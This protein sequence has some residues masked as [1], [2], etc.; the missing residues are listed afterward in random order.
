M[1]D[2]LNPRVDRV[3]VEYPF[4]RYRLWTSCYRYKLDFVEAVEILQV[5]F[6]EWVRRDTVVSGRRD[7]LVRMGE[8]LDPLCRDDELDRNE[9]SNC[10]SSRTAYSGLDILFLFSG[11]RELVVCLPQEAQFEGEDGRRTLGELARA[12]LDVHRDCFGGRMVKFSMIYRDWEE[13]YIELHLG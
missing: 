5:D 1:A 7:V 9:I 6:K 13:K 2:M 4:A 10:T 11:L 12:F 3:R 8:M